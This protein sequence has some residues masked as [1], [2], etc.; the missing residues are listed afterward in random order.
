MIC[1][2]CHAENIEGA[3]ECVNC[4]QAL[5]GL[6]VP[7]SPRGG[8]APQFVQDPIVALPKH[9][10]PTTGG[11]D[12]VGPALSARQRPD[13]PPRLHRP[14]HLLPPLPPPPR[15]RSPAPPGPRKGPKR[16]DNAA[17]TCP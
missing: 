14:R 13:N 10:A 12:P 16:R 15:R 3:D 4:G 8:Q 17:G 6:D 2:S 11:S 7:G 5:Y 1:P 9:E